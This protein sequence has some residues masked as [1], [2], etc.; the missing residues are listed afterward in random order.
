MSLV[1]RYGDL[2]VQDARGPETK[3]P[4]GSAKARRIKEIQNDGTKVIV[5]SLVEGLSESHALTKLKPEAELIRSV[6]RINKS[7]IVFG[8]LWIFPNDSSF[9]FAGSISATRYRCCG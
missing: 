8:Q 9:L 6:E 5:S 2:P 7:G 1:W 3:L 4:E